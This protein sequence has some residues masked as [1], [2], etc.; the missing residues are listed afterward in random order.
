[1]FFDK[2][3]EQRFRGSVK[4]PVEKI[5]HYP[6]KGRVPGLGGLVDEGAAVPII[7]AK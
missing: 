7:T 1:M 4:Y 2:M 6:A 5:H 3:H